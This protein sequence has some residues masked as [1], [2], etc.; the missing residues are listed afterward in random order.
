MKA[1]EIQELFIAAAE[2]DRRLPIRVKP[3]D[4]KS[5]SLPYVHDWSDVNGWGLERVEEEEQDYQR[6]IASKL[7]PSEVTL[8][9]RASDLIAKVEDESQR[10]C[11]LHWAMAKAGGRP[12]ANWCR[13]A[14]RIHEET[15]RRRKDRAVF[16]IISAI[17]CVT[18]QS[19]HDFAFQSLLPC[20]PEISDKSLNIA[21]PRHWMAEGSKPLACDIDRSLTEFAWAEDQ[22]ARRRE[23]E[24]RRKA[25]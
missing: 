9:E 23:R 6:R 8:W 5:M 17:S 20:G 11:L 15:G 1:D 24:K 19:T 18:G 21:E 25:A 4:A 14:E 13:N 16:C 22:N 2:I 12:F 3:A 7:N 10:R